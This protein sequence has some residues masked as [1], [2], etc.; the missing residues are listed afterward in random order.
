MLSYV[1]VRGGGS[2]FLKLFF[3]LLA[4]GL[5]FNFI[6]SKKRKRDKLF[7]DGIEPEKVKGNSL[8]KMMKSLFQLSIEPFKFGKNK[9]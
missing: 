5:T 7:K 8:F 9:N 2:D 3:L 1:S 6:M 4:I